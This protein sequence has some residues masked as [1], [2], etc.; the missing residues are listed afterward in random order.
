M[1]VITLRYKGQTFFVNQEASMLNISTTSKLFC[2]PR[3]VVF[4]IYKKVTRVSLGFL[5][6]ASLTALGIAQEEEATPDA[7]KLAFTLNEMNFILEGQQPN[8]PVVLEAGKSYALS[9][10]NRGKLKHEVLWGRSPIKTATGTLEDYETNLFA[11]SEAVV[12]SKGWE[13]VNAGLIELVLEP[14]Q[15]MEVMVTIPEEM[16]G[17]WDMGCFQ[18]G[19]YEAGMH[20]AITV[21]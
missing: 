20:A 16:L 2:A 18:P 15:K 9:F 4:K 10:E 11:T 13:V 21:K 3:S 14:G 19:H 12:A 7:I 1:V 8:T 5:V 6:I 17:E